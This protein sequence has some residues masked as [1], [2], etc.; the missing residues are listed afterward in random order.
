MQRADKVL[1]GV[2]S[3]NAENL[4]S[5]SSKVDKDRLL[6]DYVRSQKTFVAVHAAQGRAVTAEWEH[7]LEEEASPA[8]SALSEAPAEPDARS[9]TPVLKPRV[10]ERKQKDEINK[11]AVSCTSRARKNAKRLEH[12]DAASDKDSDKENRAMK[13]R[14]PIALTSLSPPYHKIPSLKKRKESKLHE[15]SKSQTK[16]ST[17]KRPRSPESEDDEHAAR[18]AERRERRRVK[19]AIVD[20]DIT[21][22]CTSSGEERK[23]SALRGKK[24]SK[25]KNPKGVT[26]SAGLALMHGFSATNIGKN[27]LTVCP[28]FLLLNIVPQSPAGFG[29]MLAQIGPCYRCLQ[30]GKGFR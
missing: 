24:R 23:Q 22:I 17:K 16:K 30:Q 26:M 2:A 27:R 4:R 25:A 1:H 8:I 15:V 10:P 14:Q 3:L 11:P 29:V 28:E 20:P 19:K 7:R 18:L 12:R 6:A 21:M 9:Q 5:C 13:I